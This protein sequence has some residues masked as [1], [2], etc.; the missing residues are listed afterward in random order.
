MKFLRL[1]LSV[2]GLVA[3]IV[4]ISWAF[5]RWVYP[6]PIE[7]VTSEF[8]VPGALDELEGFYASVGSADRQTF[9]D[10]GPTYID[11]PWGHAR[12]VPKSMIPH[13]FR[14]RWG[15][16]SASS[17][18]IFGDV[19]AYYDEA[20][21]LFGIYFFRSRYGCFVSPDPFRSPPYFVHS[22]RI[23]DGPVV[24]TAVDT[25]WPERTY[26]E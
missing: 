23:S 8:S 26:N 2:G 9:T 13:M 7:V 21:G 22:R 3:T 19:V 11:I 25:E 12:R 24:V 6:P 1:L 4:G 17:H 14:D 10:L 5:I 15:V 16:E 20:G 18:P